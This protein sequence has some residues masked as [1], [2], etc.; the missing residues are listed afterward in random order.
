MDHGLH[1]DGKKTAKTLRAHFAVCFSLCLGSYS[2]L[3]LTSRPLLF[4]LAFCLF[5]FF[6]VLLAFNFAHDLSH[7]AVFRNRKT[8]DTCYTLLFTL[9]GAHAAAWKERHVHEHHHAPNVTGLDPDLR[10][11]KLIRLVPGSEYRW[12]HRYQHLYAPLLYT[13]YSLY[14][15]FIKDFVILFEHGPSKKQKNGHYYASFACQKVS[16]LTLTLILPL[17]FSHQTVAIVISGFLLMH[18]LQSLF[19]LFT[20]LM[21]HHVERT[22]YHAIDDN[23]SINTSWLMNQVTSSNDMH[24]FSRTANLLL[25]GF[26]NHLAHHLYPHLNHL[27]YPELNRILYATLRQ[28]GIEPNHTSYLGGI[29][30]HIRLLKRMSDISWTATS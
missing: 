17:L 3:F 30:S 5:G 15:V 27:H 8:N 1:M 22:A 23:G 29:G 4:I 19:L 10:I 18:M 7:D 6:A 9:V 28:H 21:T 13:T 20:F 16:Y 12:Y 25:G 26:N 2:I 11:V 14:W 24:P